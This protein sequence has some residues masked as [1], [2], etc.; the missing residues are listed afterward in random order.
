[1]ICH[2][3]ASWIEKLAR[4]G[5]ASKGTV[6]AIIGLL[7]A[8]AGLGIGGKIA[9]RKDVFSDIGQTPLGRADRPR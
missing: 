3:A 1:M 5:Y 6:Y 2:Q 9:D 7:A 8:F 4:L